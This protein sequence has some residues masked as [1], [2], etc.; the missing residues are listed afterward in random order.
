MVVV[1]GD[2]CDDTAAVVV[3]PVLAETTSAA[4]EART[5][6]STRSSV[7]PPPTTD[8]G[9]PA[10]ATKNCPRP[11]LPRYASRPTPRRRV[12]PTKTTEAAADRVGGGAPIECS[13]SSAEKSRRCRSRRFFRTRHHHHQHHHHYYQHHRHGAATHRNRQFARQISNVDAVACIQTDYRGAD[14]RLATRRRLA[15]AWKPMYNESRTSNSSNRERIFQ[16]GD[17]ADTR[18]S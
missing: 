9:E 4:H 12:I 16:G 5:G 8:S 3:L 18:S 10:P 7:S 2:E 15:P 13:P 11:R 17:V 6:R 1:I 14:N